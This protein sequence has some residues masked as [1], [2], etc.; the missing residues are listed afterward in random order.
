M[1]SLRKAI[2]GLIPSKLVENKL[3]VLGT[4]VGLFIAYRLAGGIAATR[5]KKAMLDLA[6]KKRVERDAILSKPLPPININ[7]DLK[8]I[9]LESPVTKLIELLN[10]KKITSEQILVSY[11]ERAR[12]I[13]RDLELICE[14]RFEEALQEA[15]ECDKIRAKTE[16]PAELPPLFGIPISLKEV[17]QTKGLDSTYGVIALMNKPAAEDSVVITL[18]KKNGAIPFVTTNIP[19][20]LNTIESVNH[21]YGRSKN[22]W[23]PERSAG[24]S[25]GGEAGLIAARG[26]PIGLAS[27]GGG[28]TRIPSLFCGLYGFKP[29]NGRVCNSG[30]IVVTKTVR[31]KL[32]L[33]KPCFGPIARTVDD[34]I[35]MT[36]ALIHPDLRIYEPERPYIPLRQELLDTKQN[37]LR[38]A[39]FINDELFP[40]SKAHLRAVNEAVAAFK[41]RGHDVFQV[42]Q[43]PHFEKLVLTY[44]AIMSSDAGLKRVDEILKGEPLIKE[45]VMQKQFSSIPSWVKKPLA[46]LLRRFGDV[47]AS[48]FLGVSGE[49]TV[50]ALFEIV[51]NMIATQNSVYDWW[52]KNKIDVIL[53]PGLALPAFRH[54]DANNLVISASYTMI[55]NVLNMP[56][57]TV[58]VTQVTKEEEDYTTCGSPKDRFYPLAV[59][60]M[61]GAEGLPVGVQLAAL[62][63]DDE[64]CLAAMKELESEIGFHKLPPL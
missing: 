25:S 31:A 27:D 60:T 42:D 45:M 46:A 34:V 58:P 5:K 36:K 2:I 55:F 10:N 41:K 1:N 56:A 6:R 15:R 48:K 28:S 16:N 19:Q 61:Q 62:P 12:T 26:S 64:K 21:I 11:Y 49:K 54:G 3:L 43:F 63:W 37:K 20:L 13:G 32:S 57:G 8:K 50:P 51:D 7:P 38:I 33:V 35:L 14:T 59:R 44:A 39:Y 40:V 29:T 4:L 24:G 22:P 52:N 9:I 17:F 30:H 47:R 23:N 18:L 53:T